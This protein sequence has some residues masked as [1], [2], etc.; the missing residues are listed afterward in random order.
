M[1]EEIEL[2]DPKELEEKK[3][4]RF[5][6]RIALVTAIYAVVLAITSLGGNNAT[7]EMLLSQQQASDQWAFYQ[8]KG[9]KQHISENTAALFEATLF[10]RGGSISSGAK[11]R[12]EELAKS[13]KKDAARYND[14]KKEIEK[15]AKKLEE[16]RDTYRAKNPYFEYG[17][18]LLQIA[19][20]LSSI[21]ILA[22]SP[23]VFSV[24]VVSALMGA[25]LS[26]NGYLLIFRIPF[27][28]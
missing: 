4:K 9:I 25:L 27:L 16:E 1:A 17:E 28:H 12:Y 8:A 14:E 15:E 7:K 11:A 13:L 19:I 22:D 20:V 26:L 21:S 18:V 6:R 10:D 3:E 24:S 2:P 23:P 5:D